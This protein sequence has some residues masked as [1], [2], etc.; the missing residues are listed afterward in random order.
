VYRCSDVR[1]TSGEV[2][3]YTE[4]ADERMESSETSS[5]RE[6]GS[7]KDWKGKGRGKKSGGGKK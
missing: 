5:E 4:R 7:R 2:S 6:R 1:L 3:G